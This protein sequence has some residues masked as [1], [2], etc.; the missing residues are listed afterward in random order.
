MLLGTKS[1]PSVEEIFEFSDKLSTPICRSSSLARLGSSRDSL[2]VELFQ[3]ST[4]SQSLPRPWPSTSVVYGRGTEKWLVNLG[5]LVKF[6]VS[7]LALKQVFILFEQSSKL[8]L[9]F[10]FQMCQ[11]FDFF[12][13]ISASSLPSFVRGA[14]SINP[15]SS[16]SLSSSAT[17]TVAALMDNGW[18]FLRQFLCRL[19]VLPFPTSKI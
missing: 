1:S 14:S 6:G 10:S 8:L 5:K 9:S 13:S 16:P 19:S 4:A 18:N 7:R 2:M 12:P 11:S 3:P 15:S 17:M